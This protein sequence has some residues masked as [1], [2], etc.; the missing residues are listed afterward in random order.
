MCV[1]TWV[2]RPQVVP[3]R[4]LSLTCIL[5]ACLPFCLH[6]LSP[7]LLYHRCALLL[8]ALPHGFWELNSGLCDCVASTFKAIS[9]TYLCVCVST[10]NYMSLHGS[11]GNQFSP[12][13]VQ[14]P[15]VEFSSSGWV[16]RHLYT[17]SHLTAPHPWEDK[18]S[19]CSHGWP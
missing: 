16:V 12:P 4:C 5:P 13:T 19:L 10:C 18:A 11:C 7:T 2:W 14:V 15:G 3:G 6:R 9:L 1:F 8:L 17:P